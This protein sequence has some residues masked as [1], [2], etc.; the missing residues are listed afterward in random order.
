LTGVRIPTHPDYNNIVRQ[1]RVLD[2]VDKVTMLI[3]DTSLNG[4][5]NT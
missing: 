3:V 1:G 5:M 4:R 2:L